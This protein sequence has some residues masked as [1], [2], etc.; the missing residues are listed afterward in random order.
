MET[1]T[2]T[3]GAGA[4][5]LGALVVAARRPQWI[6]R[7]PRL[8]LLLTAALS[9]G[10]TAALVSLRPPGLRLEIDPSSEPLLPAGDP[11]RDAY[12]LAVREFGDDEIYAIALES[13]DVFTRDTLEALRRVTDEIARIAG[14]RTVK[15]LTDVVSFRYDPAKEWIDVGPL[16]AE[17]P[18]AAEELELLRARAVTDPLYQRNLVSPDGR[19]AAI[20][21]SFHKMTDREFI[22]G[23]F[24]GRIRRILSGESMRGRQFYLAGRPHVKSRVYE[25][26]I[27]DLRRLIPAAFA[28]I[29]LVLGA[30]SGSLRM[31]ALPLATVLVATLWTFAGVSLLDRPLTVLTTLLAPVLIAIG[32]TYGVHVLSRYDAELHRGGDLRDCVL[33]C[34]RNMLAPVAISGLTTCVGFAALL[35]TDVPAVFELGSFSVLGILSLTA[36]SLTAVPAALVAFPRLSA[37]RAGHP[38][39][40]RLIGRGL[41]AALD[42]LARLATRAPGTVI[43]SWMLLTAGALWA[44]PRIEID[45][46]YLSYFD[47]RSEIR[48]DFEAVNRLLSGAVPIY[49]IFTGPA[50]GAFLEPEALRAMERIQRRL[51]ESSGV[52]RTASMVDFVRVL[53]RVVSEDDPARERI[54]DTRSGVADLVYMIPKYDLSRFANVNQSRANIL[55]RT[56]EVGSAAIRGLVARIEE[57]LSEERLPAGV[58]AAVTGNAVLLGRS[59]DAIASGQPRSVG[60]AAVAIFLL[61][62]GVLRSASIGLV[63]MIPNVIPVAL[64]FGCLGWGAAPLSLPTSLYRAERLLGRSPAEAVFHTNRSVGRPIAI[65]SVTLILGFAVVALSGFATLRQFGLLSAGTM[66]ICTATDLIL[67]PAVLIRARI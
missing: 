55:V 23:D 6:V 17:I 58:S 30:V 26:M 24:D 14:V 42:A 29:A 22:E 45:T 57:A 65:A 15:S 56:G 51:E 50:P 32:S 37:P 25:M 52:S 47:A 16:I 60:A 5:L 59:A 10:A 9:L 40:V 46:D 18:A 21:V 1:W 53:H 48:R 38:S 3:A 13:E 63:A 19:A 36:L 67:L 64:F 62:S 54:P 2:F 41:D 35:I 61:V 7:W 33:R 44:I 28:V 34:L 39:P 43:A 27:E 66:A 8:V 31:V 12:Q 4:A 49:A 11:A 20:N